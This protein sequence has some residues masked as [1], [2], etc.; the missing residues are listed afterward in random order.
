[1]QELIDEYINEIK[2]SDDF[3]K[4]IELKKLI[5]SKYQSLIMSFNVKRD[6]YFEAEKNKNYYKDFDLIKKEY[7]DI[8]TQLFSKEEV[9]EYI[10]LENKINNRLDEDFNKVKES[11][12][13]KFG[14]SK[15][16]NINDILSR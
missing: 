16:I 11:I 4:L 14:K 2:N 8:K 12:S 15:R 9:K 10:N 6:N 3:K 7:I 5:D 1:M 13:S